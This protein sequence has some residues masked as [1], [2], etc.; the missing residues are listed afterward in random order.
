[1]EL[2]QA[3]PP[4]PAADGVVLIKFMILYTGILIVAVLLAFRAG[5]RKEDRYPMPNPSDDLIKQ[6]GEDPI[7]DKW[8]DN[9]K[10]GY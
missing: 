6:Y 2:L 10:S 4:D 7:L 9:E 3:V 8:T 5:K 1:M